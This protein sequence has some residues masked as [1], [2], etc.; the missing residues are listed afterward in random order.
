MLLQLL[1]RAPGRPPGGSPGAPAA[2][3]R[4]H[5]RPGPR[6]Q[7][8]REEEVLALQGGVRWVVTVTSPSNSAYLQPSPESCMG[9]YSV[10]NVPYHPINA[11]YQTHE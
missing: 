3:E 11:M 4:R 1:A 6:A 2:G 5:P 8:Q 9:Q 7:R 10:I